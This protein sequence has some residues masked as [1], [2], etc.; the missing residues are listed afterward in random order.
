MEVVFH[1]PKR[2]AGWQSELC[3]QC[4]A[5]YALYSM[6]SILC[7]VSYALYS[8]HCILCIVLYALYSMHCILCIVIYAFI[9]LLKGWGPTTLLRCTPLVQVN[10]ASISLV[11]LVKER[12]WVST[13]WTIRALYSMHCILC[14]ILYALFYASFTNFKGKTFK[15]CN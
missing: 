11:V 10:Q 14:I 5:F 12:S 3:I 2:V 4:I 1:L 15:H 8:M 6:H 9:K 13:T 7:I